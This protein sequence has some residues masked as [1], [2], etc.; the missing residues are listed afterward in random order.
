MLCRI[1]NTIPA[2]GHFVAD[3]HIIAEWPLLIRDRTTTLVD[4]MRS[5]ADKMIA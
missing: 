4:R 5:L 3:I 2:E 1:G